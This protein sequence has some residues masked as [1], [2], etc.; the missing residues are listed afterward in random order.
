MCSVI[1]GLT[2]LGGY[3][4][5]RQQQAQAESQAAA[6]R[7]QAAVAEAQAKVDAQ[8]AKNQARQKEVAADQAADEQRR[9]R[10]K[11]R[12]EAGSQAASTGAAGLNFAGSAL[13]I[14]SSSTEAFRQDSANLLT[15]QRET[16]HNYQQQENNLLASSENNKIT[17]GNYRAAADNV[18]SQAKLSG[19]GTIIGTAASIGGT[20][21]SNSKIWNNENDTFNT[22]GSTGNNYSFYDWGNQQKKKYWGLRG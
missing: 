19:L 2:A 8:N 14:L 6:Y 12:L 21:G 18:E 4:T 20:I 13:D 7:Q 11:Y 22:Y 3:F 16:V 17:A 5:Y 15:N 1:A 10:A 9:L